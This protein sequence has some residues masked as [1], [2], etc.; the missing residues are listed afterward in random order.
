MENIGLRKT[1]TLDETNSNLFLRRK[2]GGSKKGTRCSARCPIS[3][4]KNMHVICVIS[5]IKLIY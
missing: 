3:K 2:Y 5:Q 4:G 1:D